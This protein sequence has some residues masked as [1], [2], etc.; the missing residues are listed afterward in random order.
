MTLLHVTDD[1]NKRL[2]R[3]SGQRPRSSGAQV[4]RVAYGTRAGVHGRE[5]A[6][7]GAPA[8]LTIGDSAIAGKELRGS[9]Q[10]GVGREGNLRLLGGVVKAGNVDLLASGD[11]GAGAVVNLEGSA[12]HFDP[13]RKP[14][15]IENHV[16]LFIS[17]TRRGGIGNWYGH[18]HVAGEWVCLSV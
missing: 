4:N 5:H 11:A 3:G 1:L 12:F 17:S 18:V 9:G 15:W 16:V 7:Q 10:Q 2:P 6:P 13:G 8:G 14:S